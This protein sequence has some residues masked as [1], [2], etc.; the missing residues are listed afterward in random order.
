MRV[1]AYEE[2]EED[3]FGAFA[4]EPLLRNHDAV[5]QLFLRLQCLLFF[6]VRRRIHIYEEDTYICGGGYICYLSR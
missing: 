6:A 1:R 2:E 4:H 3:T 5:R